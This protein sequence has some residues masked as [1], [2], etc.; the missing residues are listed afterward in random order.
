M[1]GDDP[2]SHTFEFG[3]GLDS[4]LRLSSKVFFGGGNDLTAAQCQ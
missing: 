4:R 3:V 2:T 1:E